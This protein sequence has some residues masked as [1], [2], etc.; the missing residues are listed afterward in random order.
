MNVHKV[1]SLCAAV[2]FGKKL[3]M[4]EYFN[5]VGC[6]ITEIAMLKFIHMRSNATDDVDIVSELVF[7][8]ELIPHMIAL[9]QDTYNTHN[10]LVAKAQQTNNTN[11]EL[12]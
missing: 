5:Q 1:E 6:S 9:L 7:P 3:K 8:T 2:A 4:A 12:S 11:K 10:E